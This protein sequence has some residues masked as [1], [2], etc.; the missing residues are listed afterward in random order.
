V[1]D[2]TLG[3]KKYAEVQGQVAA[4]RTR[5][6]ALRE[7]A[8]RLV[9][10]DIEAYGVVARAM[11]LPR[12]TEEE[13][14]QRRAAMQEALKGAAEPPLETM[15]VASDVLRLAGDLVKI[16]NRSAIS[17]VGTA[18]LAARAGY[19]AARLNVDANV[20]SVHDVEWVSRMKRAVEALPPPDD[21]EREVLEVVETSIRGG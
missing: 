17:D 19:H 10:E 5:A 1:S 11:T 20:A 6:E 9:D 8:T 21:V 12:D 3:R 7:R 2:L 16:G 4:I 15:G 13:K 14:A 18:A